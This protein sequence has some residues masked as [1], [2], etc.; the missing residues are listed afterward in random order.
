[1]FEGEV[2]IYGED[3]DLHCPFC[4]EP[5][6]VTI[7]DFFEGVQTCQCCAN[8]VWVEFGIDENGKKRGKVEEYYPPLE[9]IS[10]GLKAIDKFLSSLSG[11]EEE[12]DK[13]A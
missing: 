7:L 1:M 3:L 9:Q 2:I 12:D 8:K 5:I 10:R 11:K 6:E 4:S 13:N